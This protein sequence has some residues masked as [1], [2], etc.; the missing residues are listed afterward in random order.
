MFDSVLGILSIFL[1]ALFAVLAYFSYFK[2]VLRAFVIAAG[3]LW[4]AL[5]ITHVSSDYFT[6]NGIDEAAIYH[7]WYGFEGAG[8]L[9]YFK[10]ILSGGIALLLLLLTLLWVTGRISKTQLDGRKVAAPCV[11]LLGS[12]ILNPAVHDIKE[13]MSAQ[14]MQSEQSDFYSYYQSPEITSL[15][16]KKK[17]IVFI[18]AE[19]LE[20]TYLDES[21]FPGLLN[22]I[23]SLESK[24]TYFTDIKQLRGTGWTIGGITASQCGIPLITPSHVNSMSG[25]EGFLSGTTCF[26]DVMSSMG[27]QLSF[28]GGANLN[29]GGKG[30]FFKTHGFNNV[31]GRI[32]LKDKLKVGGYLSWWGLYDDVVLNYAY[33]QFEELSRQDQPF[34]LFTLTLDTHHPKGHPSRRCKGLNYQDGENAILNSVKCSDFLIS[35]FIGKIENSE[36]AKDTIVVLASDHL[37]MRNTAFDQLKKGNRRDLFMILDLENPQSKQVDVMGSTL[38]IGATVL[39]FMGYEG[40]IGLGRDLLKSDPQLTQD[41]HKKLKSWDID[42]LKFWE[43][44]RVKGD[45]H[46]NWEEKRILLGGQQIKLPALLEIKPNL[47]TVA[48]FQFNRSLYH[49]TFS[50]DIDDIPPESYFVLFESCENIAKIE[51]TAPEGEYCV[52]S[53]PS[54]SEAK[55]AAMNLTTTYSAR[56]FRELVGMEL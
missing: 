36:Y 39:P 7:L 48:R 31:E 42:I 23:K 47:T 50:D 5:T 25:L 38:D 4:I 35:E 13:L 10:L 45:T 34:G 30:K 16:S 24:S 29:F 54:K 27:Y 33:E 1:F 9:E 53:G 14:W 52:L 8:F 43:F 22:G 28:V 32:E 51:P 26:G 49:K 37:A 41:V 17:N 56:D 12:V 44:P 3:L 21:L 11:L 2:P 15:K 20:R 6:G 18:Y 46:I 40:A 19:S 55:V